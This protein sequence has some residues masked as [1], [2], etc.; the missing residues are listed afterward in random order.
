MK[1]SN[2]GILGWIAMFLLVIGGLNIGFMGVF[3]YNVLAGIFGNVHVLLLRAIY[4]FIGLA[5]VLAIFGC[6][7]KKK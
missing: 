4:V 2:M 3:D 1:G 5:A 7:F 6:F